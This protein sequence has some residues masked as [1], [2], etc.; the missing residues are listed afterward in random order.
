MTQ[1]PHLLAGAS[2]PP[3]YSCTINH[4]IEPPDPFGIVHA[5]Y[6]GMTTTETN[7]NPAICKTIIAQLGN[8]TLSMLGAKSLLDLGNGLSFR[9][10]G[11]RSVNYI[12]IE[13]DAGTDTYSVRT[14]KIGRAP[15][16]QIS[17]DNTLDGVYVDQ[18]HT[19]IEGATGLATSL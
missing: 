8:L 5:Y 6:I 17:N 13:L 16:Y 19:T 1:L 4:Y 12:A 10:R 3:R 18:L 15:S 2:R 14:A 11:S 7:T 9:V